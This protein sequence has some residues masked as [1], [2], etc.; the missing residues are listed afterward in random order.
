MDTGNTKH[1][2]ALQNLT[3]RF[4]D[5]TH[6]L[7]L[8]AMESRLMEMSDAAKN[9]EEQWRLL[10]LARELKRQ[11]AT[12]LMAFKR[13]LA[14]GFQAFQRGALGG[15]D[16]SKQDM[17]RDLSLMA[18]EELEQDLATSSLARRAETRFSEELFFLNQRLAM[19]RGGRKLAEDG[20]PLGAY[21]FAGALQAEISILKLDVRFAVLF[22]RVFEKLLLENLGEFYKEANDYLVKQGVLPNLRFGAGTGSQAPQKTSA[23]KQQKDATKSDGATDT[24]KRVEPEVP[25]TPEQIESNAAQRQLYADICGLQGASADQQPPPSGTPTAALNRTSGGNYQPSFFS[26]PAYAAQGNAAL[27]MCSQN[28]VVTAL[29]RVSQEQHAEVMDQGIVPPAMTVQQFQGVTQQL[30]E[31]IGDDKRLADDDGRTIDLVGMIF[32]YMLG[33]KQLPDSVKA[34]LSYLHTPYL[35]AA[36]IDK[37]L[38]ENPEHSS[39]QL[40]NCLAEAGTRW[41]N[42]DGDSQFKVFPKIKSVIRRVLTDFHSDIVVFDELLVEMR[43]FN[44]KVEHNIEVMERR[45]REKAEGE[46]RLRE[47]K[48]RVLLEVRKRMDGYDLPSHIIVLLLH[49]WS[50]YLTFTLLRHG[51][52]SSQWQEGI[53][54]IDEIVWSVQEKPD[55]N[56]RNRLMLIQDSL[57]AR[58]QAGLETIAHDQAK[59]N[60]LLDALSKSQML[61]LQSLVAEPATAEKRAEMEAEVSVD[62]EQEDI[63]MESLSSDEKEM[64]NTLSR[65]A[66]GTWIEFDHLDNYE[67]L[68]ARIAWFNAKTSHY[69]LV[70][71]TGKQ[72]AM[73][74]GLEISRMIL[75][76]QARM[77]ADSGKPFFE[78]A[79]ENVFAR[80]KAVVVH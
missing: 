57:Q 74:S 67:N 28:E 61:V 1:L 21:Q 23:K 76:S 55:L 68:R 44:Q 31:Q 59:S 24:S 10:Q 40:L 78:R 29:A 56:E 12:L 45:A 49:P 60:K 36:F 51:E 53:D 26:Q 46:D 14:A 50:D 77:L 79:L 70:D 39:R 42:S 3:I 27:A 9:N 43:E 2:F 73:K 41:V 52:E 19:L 35:K 66:F 15:K 6:E 17:S 80:L 7:F 38:F 58:V 71:R 63:D 64:M 65:V 13:H 69:M 34:V 25:Q 75:T 22:F 62:L 54:T 18:D 11:K 72:V 8:Q 20:N 37:K 48:R 47:V 30:R 33:D 5:K 16:T 4:G 32:E